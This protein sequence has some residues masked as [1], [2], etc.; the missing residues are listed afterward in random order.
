MSWRCQQPEVIRQYGEQSQ[1][2]IPC[3]HC[4]GC[5]TKW[6]KGWVLRMMLEAQSS[7]HA[8]F[9][10]LTY[11]TGAGV[12][13]LDY[14]HVAGF[15]KRWRKN[16]QQAV[17]F[18]SCGEFGDRFGRPHWHLILFGPSCEAMSVG[19]CSMKEWPFGAVMVGDATPASMAY[20][21]GYSLKKRCS[22]IKI[23]MSRRPG[24]G[25]EK[26]SELGQ[27]LAETV[28]EVETFPTSIRIGKHLYPLHRRARDVMQES[29]LRSNGRIRRI[30]RLGV[31]MEAEAIL[32]LRSGQ[33]RS[34]IFDVDRAF[35]KQV[36]RNLEKTYAKASAP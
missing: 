28:H 25:L 10:T 24:I 5:E 29:F 26:L 32:A 14:Q 12:S 15:L 30:G 22:E 7:V 6:R 31:S 33:W 9:L 13:S 27:I 36:I 20:V 19:V 1:M 21:A 3:G 18:F 8:R 17:R 2:V 4:L 35:S 34:Q 23:V 16:T 11:Q